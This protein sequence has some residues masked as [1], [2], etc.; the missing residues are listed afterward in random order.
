M[1]KI[2]IAVLYTVC[3]L[4]IVPLAAVLFRG[5]EGSTEYVDVYIADEDRVEKME[6][7]QY[8]KGVVAAEM[9]ASFEQEALKAQAVAART[10]LEEKRQET[11]PPEHKGAA[12]CTDSTHCC[13]WTSEEQWVSQI[14]PDK[15]DEY[16]DKISNAVDSTDGEIITYGGEPISAVFHSTSSGMT[17]RAADVWGNDVPY[18]QSVV[19]EGEEK[20]PKFT[21]EYTCTV[22]EYKAKISENVPGADMDKELISDIVRSEAGGIISAVVCGVRIS[23][24]ELRNIFGLRSA[25]ITVESDGN[26]VKFSVKGSGH[27]VGMSQY[28]ANHLASVGKSYTEILAAYYIGTTVEKRT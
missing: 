11:P 5:G 13:A 15:A 22:D 21:S 19:S 10:Y 9:P 28:G 4:I 6:V 20:S 1:R 12:V 26:T 7:S 23:G 8:L 17:E 25:N 3:M 27:G 16:R 2:V 18:L 24:T 14:D